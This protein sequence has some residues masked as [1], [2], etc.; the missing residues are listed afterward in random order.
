VVESWNAAVVRNKMKDSNYAVSAGSD[1]EEN[2]D[3]ELEKNAL[4]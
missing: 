2:W 1:V 4:K 3:D